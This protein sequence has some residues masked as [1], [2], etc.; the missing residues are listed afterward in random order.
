MPLRTRIHPWHAAR[1]VRQHRVDGSPLNVGEF[2]AHDSWLRFGSLNHPP[3][4]AI[5]PQRAIAAD[6][7]TLILLLLSGEQLTFPDLLPASSR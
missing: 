5:D 3:G 7:N 4:D 1:L 2:V 6:A